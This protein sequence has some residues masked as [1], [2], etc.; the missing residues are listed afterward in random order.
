[1][2]SLLNNMELNME[3]FQLLQHGRNEGLKTN[4]TL[5]SETTLKSSAHLKDLGVTVADDLT[6]R[7]HITKVVNEGKKFTFWILRSFK[8]RSTVLLHLFKTFVI[9]KLEYASPLW[10][11]HMKTD[12]EKI[13]ALQRTLTSR[14]DGMKNLDYHE[15]LRSLKIYSLQRR[16]ERFAI[17]TVWK[18]LNGLH[19]NQLH[20]DFY[21]THR[22]GIKCR[23][24]VSKA[25]R[26]HIRTLYH[27]SFASNGPALFNTIPK[28][29][30][31]KKT[32]PSFKSALDQ[33]LKSMPDRP[34]IAG[35]PFL[36][37]N[38]IME[39]TGSGHHSQNVADGD[40]GI[41]GE[42]AVSVSS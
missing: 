41:Y 10:M 8:T 2:W 32:L 1:M 35:Y 22:F 27:N 37:G 29:V 19:P 15:R 5:D 20:L 13:E 6:W 30:K 28:E 21:E 31:E 25:K 24:R 11:P 9:S 18:I 39:W 12:I 42:A 36:N 7:K 3:K 16:R 26:V 38:S 4:C 23:R 17:I 34:P 40:G 14:L 33:F